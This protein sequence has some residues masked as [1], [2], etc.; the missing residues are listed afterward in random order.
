MIEL[1]LDQFPVVAAL[2]PDELGYI[3]PKAVIEHR[4]PGWVFADSLINPKAALVW[5]QGNRGIYLM[6]SR[7]LQYRDEINSLIDTLIKPRL[8]SKGIKCLEISTVPP[9]TDK[10]L[11]SLFQERVLGGWQQSVYIYRENAKA[12]DVPI[13]DGCL[14]NIKGVLATH[15]NAEFARAKILGYWE[16]ID[17]FNA[18]GEGYCVI[19]DDTVVSL[20]ITGWIAGNTHEISIET[21]EAYRGRGFAKA[22]ASAL[23]NCSLHKG[24]VPYWECETE[25]TASARIAQGLG[26]TKLYD[27]ICY[28]FDISE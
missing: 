19:S 6:G 25:N 1:S 27:Y 11:K 18:H 15:A 20:A 2:F 4:N 5:N 22:C 14:C 28:G 3:E 12:P 13:R 8:L 23:V 10:E 7:V 21:V 17:S 9:V 16:S 24:C 26:F